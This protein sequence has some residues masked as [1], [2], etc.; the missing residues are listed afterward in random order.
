MY[1]QEARQSMSNAES[2]QLNQTMLDS[3]TQAI[4]HTIEGF[5]PPWIF[6]LAFYLISSSST[7][8]NLYSSLAIICR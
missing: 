4:Y 3:K 8:I 1:P 5:L 7:V 6:P 2:H